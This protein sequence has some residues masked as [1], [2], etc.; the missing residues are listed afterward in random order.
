MD[1]ARAHSRSLTGYRAKAYLM[2]DMVTG[3][4]IVMVMAMVMEIVIVLVMVTVPGFHI[5]TSLPTSRSD[6]SI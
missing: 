5:L 1:E 3:M 4:E 2:T 6:T